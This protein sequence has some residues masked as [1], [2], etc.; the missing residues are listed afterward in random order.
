MVP[1]T[2]RVLIQTAT[3]QGGPAFIPGVF[4]TPQ[5]GREFPLPV[6]SAEEFMAIL[7]LLQVPGPLFFDR[8]ALI[9][10]A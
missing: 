1:A 9:K 5:G 7:A 6:N 2:V 8:G 4:V 3:P 10:N